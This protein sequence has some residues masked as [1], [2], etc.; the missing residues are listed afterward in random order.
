MIIDSPPDCA[1]ER[2]DFG[3]QMLRLARRWRN[4]VDGHLRGFGV[5]SATWRAL[6]HVGEM[7]GCVRPKDLSEVLEMERPSLTQLLDR[8][9]A[10][11]LVERRADP[12]DH[13]CKNVVLTTTGTEIHRHTVQVNALVAHKLMHDISDEDLAVVQSV[14]DRISRN[15]ARVVDEM[16][17][18]RP[19]PAPVPRQPR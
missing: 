15:I 14:L 13:R 17:L 5:T 1:P 8:L 9:E 11:R 18:E 16:E 12:D 4:V 10:A 6:F 3:L 7:N 19:R 2:R